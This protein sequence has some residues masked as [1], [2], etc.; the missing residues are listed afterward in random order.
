MMTETLV[1]FESTF[2]R[3]TVS[4]TGCQNASWG[5][6]GRKSR[7]IDAPRVNERQLGELGVQ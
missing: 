4:R 6:G 7:N 1:V 3:W 5:T 2:D